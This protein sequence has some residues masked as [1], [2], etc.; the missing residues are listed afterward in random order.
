M[1]D[2]PTT[3]PEDLPPQI[4][5]IDRIMSRQKKP[6][7]LNKD[8]AVIVEKD[9]QLGKC[10]G[11]DTKHYCSHTDQHRRR[12]CGDCIDRLSG[13]VKVV[14]TTPRTREEIE[15]EVQNM[16]SPMYEMA[17]KKNAEP[18]SDQIDLTVIMKGQVY[19]LVIRDQICDHSQQKFVD[20]M[21]KRKSNFC[22]ECGKVM[23]YRKPNKVKKIK[24][25][26]ERKE[27]KNVKTRTNE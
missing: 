24:E 3:P 7:V 27:K 18:I 8:Y 12:Y 15:I 22:A 2:K 5:Q 13:K 20:S 4:S 25:P 21:A 16:P 11:C 9:R 17:M 23:N 14:K 1:T 6:W 19:D 26:K 10:T